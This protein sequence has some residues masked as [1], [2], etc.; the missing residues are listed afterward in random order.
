MSKIGKRVVDDL[1]V[2]LSAL[3]YLED[4][5]QRRRVEAALQQLSSS[6]QLIP[7]VAKLNLRTGRLSLLAYRNFDEDPFPELAASWVFSPGSASV[8]CPPPA[9]PT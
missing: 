6:T 3:G 5:E 8:T 2:H 1:Y 7:S 4:L 9:V